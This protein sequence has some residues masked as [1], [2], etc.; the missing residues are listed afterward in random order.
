MQH[1]IPLLAE[2]GIGL[3]STGQTVKIPIVEGRISLIQSLEGLLM[4]PGVKTERGINLED[5]PSDL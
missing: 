1:I 3:S 4:N 5:P 2:K